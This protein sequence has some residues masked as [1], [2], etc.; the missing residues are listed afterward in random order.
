MPQSFSE[1]I[2]NEIESSVNGQSTKPIKPSEGQSTHPGYDPVTVVEQPV[3]L[4]RNLTFTVL[5]IS[6]AVSV[7]VDGILHLVLG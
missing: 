7:V 4:T 2:R 6:V 1:V 5:G 3:K